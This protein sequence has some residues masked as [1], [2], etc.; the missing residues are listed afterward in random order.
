ME[1]FKNYL[2][3]KA[4]VTP[5]HFQELTTYIKSKS[6]AK[7]TFLLQKGDVCMHT[8]FVEKGLLRSYSIDASGKEHLL[9]FASENW[10]MSDRSSVFFNEPSE[11]YID[12]I[13]DTQAFMLDKEFF[14]KATSI[15]PAFRKFNTFSLHNHIRH[16]QKRI[17]LL[18]SATAEERYL[19]F[20]NL[21]PDLTLRV[22]QWM[23]ASYLGITPESL[24]RVRRNL[25]NKNFKM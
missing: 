7:G 23:I 24:S 4:G 20:I 1:N 22:P 12:A 25:A 2:Q 11:L 9:L 19:H 17:N 8:F 18:I 10:L 13:E 3:S 14:E 6:I 5:Q 15:S 16:Q 21:Y